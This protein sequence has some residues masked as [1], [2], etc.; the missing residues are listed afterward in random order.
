MIALRVARV[1]LYVKDV[2]RIAAFYMRFVQFR[3]DKSAS[4]I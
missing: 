3:I 4:I 2:R 1:I